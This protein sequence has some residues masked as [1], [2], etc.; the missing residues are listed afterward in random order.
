MGA[1][2]GRAGAVDVLM[3]DLLNISEPEYDRRFH[4]SGM[5]AGSR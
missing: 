1:D 2:G 4:E 3:D 5:V